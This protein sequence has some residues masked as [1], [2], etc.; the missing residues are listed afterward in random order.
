MRA[1]Q[2]LTIAW[3]ACL[4]LAAAGCGKKDDSKA[5]GSSEGAGAA[6]DAV[7]EKTAT[8]FYAHYSTLEGMEVVQAYKNGVTVTGTVKRTIGEMDDSMAVWVDA[9]EPN[10][11]S[12]KFTDNGAAAKEKGLAAGAPVKATCKIGGATGK[13]IMLLDCVLK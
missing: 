6:A 13:R 10:Y 2:R 3:I 9:G 8:D 4:V 5:G 11:V 7:P 1:M 12:L